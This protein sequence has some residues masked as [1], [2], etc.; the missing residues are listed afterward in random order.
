MDEDL[1][2]LRC[3]GLIVGWFVVERNIC[4]ALEMQQIVV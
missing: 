4:G 1:V 3:V 2:G